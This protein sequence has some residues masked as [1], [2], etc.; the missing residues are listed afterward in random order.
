MNTG[1]G[2]IDAASV[3]VSVKSRGDWSRFILYEI[4][5]ETQEVSFK[6]DAYSE[7]FQ[8]QHEIRIELVDNSAD[9]A[10]G[11]PIEE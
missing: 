1:P 6:I 8:G 10:E 3:Q 7:L 11:K 4:N 2:S 5:E 9:T